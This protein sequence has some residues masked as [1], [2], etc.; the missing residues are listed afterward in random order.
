MD[1]N[2]E[3]TT[4][5]GHAVTELNIILFGGNGQPIA[6][7]NVDKCDCKVVQLQPTNTPQR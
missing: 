5:A 4:R 2:N 7:A 1:S 6:I 3:Y